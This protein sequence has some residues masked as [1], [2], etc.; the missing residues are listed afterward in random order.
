MGRISIHR[1]EEGFDN[2]LN[3]LAHYR[4]RVFLNGKMYPA[5][6]AD[7][8]AGTIQIESGPRSVTLRGT[9]EIKLKRK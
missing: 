5:T 3:L 9:V 2:Y 8:F 1:G 7:P 4:I 6:M